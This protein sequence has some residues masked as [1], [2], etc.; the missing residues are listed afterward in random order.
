MVRSLN[1]TIKGV[2]TAIYGMV[3]KSQALSHQSNPSPFNIFDSD[4]LHSSL[5]HRHKRTAKDGSIKPPTLLEVYSFIYA[6]FRKA[7]VEPE[8]VVSSL[9]YLEKFMRKAKVR[10]TP[11]NWERLVFVSIM[12]AS[13]QWDDISCSSRSFALC[14][15][16]AFSLKTLNKMERLVLFHLD[17][18]L[19]LTSNDY[20]I[21]YYRLKR[22]WQAAEIDADGSIAPIL[23]D[24]YK[25]LK[26]PSAWGADMI[27]GYE[28]IEEKVDYM[29]IEQEA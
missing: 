3:L 28:P 16:G 18:K 12:I 8:A 14:T 4:G 7:Q 21:I 19:Y 10:I 27:F 11:L 17:Y 6:L 26:V 22:L 20:R 24:T 15:N 2:S 23:P 25:S 1:R 5:Y 29:T 9:P 13:K